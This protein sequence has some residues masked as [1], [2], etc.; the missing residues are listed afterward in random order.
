MAVMRT[1]VM[2]AAPRLT[3]RLWV[4][5]VMMMMIAIVT[6][7]E[8]STHGKKGDGAGKFL[9][10]RQRKH[11]GSLLSFE[12]TCSSWLYHTGGKLENPKCKIK[13]S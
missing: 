7:G 5:T 12:P 9:L 2:L 4:T 1:P 8:Q 10:I 13:I 11:Y 6:A 3:R